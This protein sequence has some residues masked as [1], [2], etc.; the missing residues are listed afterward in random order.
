MELDRTSHA[1]TGIVL[2]LIYEG[3]ENVELD[4]R[5]EGLVEEGTN[6]IERVR[7]SSLEQAL[8]RRSKLKG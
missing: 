8:A 5:V 3:R 2:S 7:W 4:R 1:S 6:E